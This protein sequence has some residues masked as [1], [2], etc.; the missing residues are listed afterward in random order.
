[1]YPLRVNDK[2]TESN[3]GRRTGGRGGAGGR[4]QGQRRKTEG[5]LVEEAR[6]VHKHITRKIAKKRTEIKG[7]QLSRS[8]M[9]MIP[10]VS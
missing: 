4:R 5:K 7:R 2:H 9:L 6:E 10:N 8:Q 3:L 1:M